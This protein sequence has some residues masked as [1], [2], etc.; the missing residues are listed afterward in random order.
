[1]VM[2]EVLQGLTVLMTENNYTN[3]ILTLNK[4][5]KRDS[6][7]MVQKYWNGSQSEQTSSDDNRELTDHV[8][9]VLVRKSIDY[10]WYEFR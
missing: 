10:H 8:F 4:L 7:R 1:M 3:L 9:S 5:R 6:Q 2:T